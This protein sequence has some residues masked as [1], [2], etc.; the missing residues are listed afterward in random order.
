M[1][2]HGSQYKPSIV[3]YGLFIFV[4]ASIMI[5]FHYFATPSIIRGFLLSQ[6]HPEDEKETLV[7]FKDGVVATAKYEED[8]T[9][10]DRFL[11]EIHEEGGEK[12]KKRIPLRHT[13]GDFM[14]YADV[15]INGELINKEFIFDFDGFSTREEKITVPK[16]D[17]VTKQP[18]KNEEGKIL[19]TQ[20][21]KDG[22]GKKTGEWYVKCPKLGE[23][24]IMLESWGFSI[25]AFDCGMLLGMIL[26]MMLPPSL[27]YI[28]QK[29]E[30]EMANTKTKIRLNTGFNKET[31]EIIALRDSDFEKFYNDNPNFIKQIFAKVWARTQPD[32]EIAAVKQ[33]GS[34]M[35]NVMAAFRNAFDAEVQV[36]GILGFRNETMYGRIQESYSEAV[37]T[38]I[39]NLKAAQDWQ[40]ARWKIMPALRLYMAHHFT[41]RYAN[42]VTGFA[43][44]GAAILIIVVGIRGLKF[45]PA[46]RPSVMLWA[47]LLEFTLL[48]LMA[49]SLFYT[50]EEER[51]DKML[52]KMEDSGKSQLSS[53]KGM[54]EDMTRVAAGLGEEGLGVA[55]KQMS[56][57][58]GK[59]AK[60]LA[61]DMMADAIRSRVEEAVERHLAN[62]ED[63]KAAVKEALPDVII[64][65]LRNGTGG[66]SRQIEES[67]SSEIDI[68]AILAASGQE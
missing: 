40:K 57:D 33:Q 55:M 38:E 13:K 46:A 24:A 6:F 8:K 16:I 30:R 37:M 67:S 25:L 56:T 11:V 58:M 50:E 32:H 19:Q 29:F 62:E 45:I 35:A 2:S 60:T 42:N 34:S 21:E 18:E 41:E 64:N 44:G 9:S 48:A 36:G 31:V 20:V 5:S 26:T 12:V 47:I 14:Y 4:V 65:A 7:K 27:G 39:E 17:P 54:A 68:D 23:E 63:I 61:D 51:M 3:H 66:G 22:Y 49:V 1:S 15:P 53:L 59:I 28:S 52:K 10:G 43:Y